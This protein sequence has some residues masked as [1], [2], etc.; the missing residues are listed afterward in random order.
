MKQAVREKCANTE[1]F[2]VRIFLYLDR[3]IRT[4]K[5]S[6][7]T[8]FSRSEVL[9]EKYITARTDQINLIDKRTELIS[10]CRHKNKYINIQ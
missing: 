1:F 6:V 7:F 3:K 9:T 2:L 4:R 5:N 8:Q 10:K